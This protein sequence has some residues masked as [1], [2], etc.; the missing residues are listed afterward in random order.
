MCSRLLER[1]REERRQQNPI[2]SQHLGGGIYVVAQGTIQKYPIHV[3]DH[4]RLRHGSTQ[5]PKANT[6]FSAQCKARMGDGKGYGRIHVYLPTTA[7]IQCEFGV[8]AT[9]PVGI[10]VA[11]EGCRQVQRAKLCSI[12]H[13]AVNWGM[14][15]TEV[16]IRNMNS[17]YL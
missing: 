9:G 11:P 1:H 5:S 3:S 2:F 10:W 13:K 17:W 12:A 8:S 4:Q 15:V 14:S 7:L 16:V 6:F